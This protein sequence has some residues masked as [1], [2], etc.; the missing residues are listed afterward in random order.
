MALYRLTKIPLSYVNIREMPDLNSADIGDLRPGDIVNVLAFDN[1][2]N[3]VHLVFQGVIGYVSLQSGGVIFTRTDN[4]H[5]YVT[6]VDVSM[7][8][9]A[10]D[11]D[12]VKAAGVSFAIIRAT[13]GNQK[14]RPVGLDLMFDDHSESARN[15]GLKVGAYHAYLPAVTGEDQAQFFGSVVDFGNGAGWYNFSP[16]IDV[17]ITNDKAPAVI[18]ERLHVMCQRLEQ[19]FQIKPMIYTSP[20]FWNS[21]I[22]PTHDDYFSSLPLWV[23]HWTAAK[24]PTLPRSWKNAGKDWTIWQYSNAGTV[25]GINGR[26]DLN[27]MRV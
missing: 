1:P 5:T 25:A 17:E 6:G 21:Y 24:S 2:K 3:W 10:A 20:G 9:N 13:Q 7:Y 4:P 11:W 23:A 15:A 26:V 8:Q 19:D 12:K 27:R 18:T 22:L 14:S 16:A